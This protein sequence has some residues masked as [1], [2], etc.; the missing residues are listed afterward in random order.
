MF[1]RLVS[2]IRNIFG[3]KKAVS[4]TP[5]TFIKDQQHVHDQPKPFRPE[6][7]SGVHHPR[8]LRQRRTRDER[9][10]RKQTTLPQETPPHEHP[11][12]ESWDIHEFK[13]PIADGKMRFHDLELPKDIL[14]AVHDLG[15]N[16]CTPVQAETLPKSLMGDDVSA[17]AQTGTGKTAAFLITIFNHFIKNPLE[18][19]RRHGTP[20]ALILAPTRELV[21]QI[22]NDAHGLGKYVDCGIL[23][24]VGGIDYIRQQNSLKN[25]QIDVLVCTPGRLLDFMKK[26]LVDLKKVEILVLDEADRMLDMGFIP[27]VKRIVLSTPPKAKRQTM[28]FSAT[29][30]SD[31]ERLSDSWTRQ[32]IQVKIMPEDVAVQSVEQITYITTRN[33]K[34]TLL[35]NLINQKHLERVL[36]FA[37]RKDEARRLKNTL[38]RYG[39]SCALLSGD[40]DQKQRLSRLERFR[41]GRVRVL[42]A[43]DV[44]SRGLHIEG[45]TH[46]INYNL[47]SDVEDYVHRIGRTGRAGATGISIN[48]A[49]EEDSYEIPKIE[50]F[51]GNKI[52][53]VYP[54][55]NLL[56]PIPPIHSQSVATQ[57]EPSE[58]RPRKQYRRSKK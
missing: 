38:E 57:N 50:E 19:N 1:N 37:N 25:D 4:P 32:A 52:I 3:R 29:I 27:D 53:C 24:V 39:I 45:I 47:S 30:T 56:V 46:V 20:R 40:V 58:K 51:I 11:P 42:V 18:D 17:Q 23:S 22:E 12:I 43:T 9:H 35:Y 34:P 49:D 8:D 21:I 13:V 2:R 48:F 54:E 44:A 55:P 31:V 28:F 26:K 5:P 16:Y 14:H 41:D 33:E 7:P 15:Y 10:L 36:I 6:K